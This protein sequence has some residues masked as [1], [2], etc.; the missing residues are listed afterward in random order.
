MRN[1]RDI[2]TR[3]DRW[4]ILKAL[5]VICIVHLLASARAAVALG[6]DEPRQ[7]EGVT[8]DGRA[9]TASIVGD[10]AVVQLGEGRAQSFPIAAAGRRVVGLEVVVRDEETF[11]RSLQ[12]IFATPEA[13]VPS[14]VV[15]PIFEPASTGSREPERVPSDAP[16]PA[17]PTSDAFERLFD[18]TRAESDEPQDD[19]ELTMLRVRTESQPELTAGTAVVRFRDEVRYEITTE[20]AG[21]E[22]DVEVFLL[23]DDGSES[24]LGTGNGNFR[25]AESPDRVGGKLIARLDDTSRT[26][27]LRPESIRVDAFVDGDRAR[28]TSGEIAS[29]GRTTPGEKLVVQK[30]EAIRF[31]VAPDRGGESFTITDGT[32]RTNVSG[33]MTT[34]DRALRGGSFQAALARLAESP[35]IDIDVVELM[36]IHLETDDL[37]ATASRDAPQ[38]TPA[39]A[40]R[41][42]V[43]RATLRLEMIPEGHSFRGRIGV[44]GTKLGSSRT[45]EQPFEGTEAPFAPLLKA[46]GRLP[47]AVRIEV[48]PDRGD[49]LEL[50]VRITNRQADGRFDVEGPV[51]LF[52]GERSVTQGGSPFLGHLPFVLAKRGPRS[53]QLHIADLEVVE[54]F[55][56]GP[57]LLEAGSV[58]FRPLENEKA[59]EIVGTVTLKAREDALPDGVRERS[60]QLVVY[61]RGPNRRRL[62]AVEVVVNRV[63]VEIVALPRTIFASTDGALWIEFRVTSEARRPKENR[64]FEFDEITCRLFQTENT[65]KTIRRQLLS[66]QLETKETLLRDPEHPG[67]YVVSL[68]AEILRELEP[69][70]DKD[71]PTLSRFRIDDLDVQIEV[72][73]RPVDSKGSAPADAPELRGTSNKKTLRSAWTHQITC[74]DQGKPKS[75]KLEWIEAIALATLTGV[76]SEGDATTVSVGKRRVENIAGFPGKHDF[77]ARGYRD[78]ARFLA[79]HQR[80]IVTHEL[81]KTGGSIGV[82][83]AGQVHPGVARKAKL[84]LSTQDHV[85]A[86]VF[87]VHHAYTPSPTSTFPEFEAVKGDSNRTETANI[88]LDLRPAFHYQSNLDDVVGG[89]R[90]RPGVFAD[91]IL[92]M[93]NT[94][95]DIGLA[96]GHPI[97]QGIALAVKAFVLGREAL[98]ALGVFGASDL[99][100]D[101]IDF[102]MSFNG[103]AAAITVSMDDRAAVSL[104]PRGKVISRVTF[105]QSRSFDRG[106]SSD[107]H[108]RAEFRTAQ[109]FQSGEIYVFTVQ[110]NVSVWGATH[111]PKTSKTPVVTGLEVEFEGDL[112]WSIQWKGTD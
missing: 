10:N 14:L 12:R 68:P 50:S 102:P 2:G 81:T 30:G 88:E 61:T 76:T 9:F 71:N 7:F 27:R 75:G 46:A 111:S 19:L 87:G 52:P 69:A 64:H 79:G 67:R 18:A 21:R 8:E 39:R 74:V 51:S 40:T 84:H 70:S 36:A 94:L 54:E 15:T 99:D 41:E 90:F 38:E 26:V 49:A 34:D 42:D 59:D 22:N 16:P 78:V 60:T 77:G 101:T 1:I 48:R 45:H 100:F 37:T 6:Q 24:S 91:E 33:R 43:A 95:A 35:V 25:F 65:S 31:T 62:D 97:T 73:C 110:T 58:A 92:T 82:E 107:S 105:P 13:A 17:G 32:Q 83:A 53:E 86:A 5:A 11:N 112:K 44:A 28:A 57:G 72:A 109:S 47:T 80:P 55:E 23:T 20:P 98:A 103:A 96:K 106:R 93:T 29:D 3:S 66:A 85:L 89:T 104:Q 4:W 56:E 108:P 63:K